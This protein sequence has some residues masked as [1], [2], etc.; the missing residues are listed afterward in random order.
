MTTVAVEAAAL[1]N[2]HPAFLTKRPRLRSQRKLFK[3]RKKEKDKET[4]L[5]EEWGRT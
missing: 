3:R 2:V 1:A 4:N 5:K